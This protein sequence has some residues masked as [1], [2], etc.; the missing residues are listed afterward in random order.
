MALDLTSY[1][2][3]DATTLIRAG[4]ERAS[5]AEDGS[6][7]FL[8]F[9]SVTRYIIGCEVAALTEAQRDTLIDSLDVSVT[10]A[11][12]VDLGTRTYTG[13]VDTAKPIKWR[14]TNGLYTVS[15]TLRAVKN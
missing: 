13:K 7:R 14:G 4:G 5:I 8:D 15:F 1:K 11:V 12:T 2:L 10:D 6:V 9:G 3:S